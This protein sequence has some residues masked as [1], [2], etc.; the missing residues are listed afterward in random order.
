MECRRVLVLAVLC[1]A[2]FACS[3]VP[4][5]S[6]PEPALTADDLEVFAAVV[7]DMIR[8]P[9]ETYRER[10]KQRGFKVNSSELFLVGDQTL[11]TCEIH[12]YDPRRCVDR[13]LMTCLAAYPLALQDRS[14]R[15]Y[16]IGSAFASDILIVDSDYYFSLLRAGPLRE[17]LLRRYPQSE[18]GDAVFFSV[19]L[20]PRPREAVVLIRH[21]SNGASC[22]LLRLK[23]D[24]W[25]VERAFGGWVE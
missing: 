11:K 13:R 23:S 2:A 4:L 12:D 3:S 6:V 17:G 18:N 7:N 21:Y 15:S 5:P 25:S 9:R 24:G 14:R 20:Y 16:T 19:P 8:K 1:A 22:L 10:L